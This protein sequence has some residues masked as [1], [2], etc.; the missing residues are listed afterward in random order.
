MNGKL[1]KAREMLR[2]FKGENYVFGRG[3]LQRVGDQAASLGRRVAVVFGGYDKDWARPMQQRVLAS[4]AAAGLQVVDPVPGARPN[5]PREDVAR[6][7]RALADIAP[8]VI[9]AGGS[10]STIDAVKAVAAMVVLG[11]RRVVVEV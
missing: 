1:E 5:T 9:V 7:R 6:I 3:C 11:E 4:L 8:D 10:G 2:A